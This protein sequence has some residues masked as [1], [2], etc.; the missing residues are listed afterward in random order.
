VRDE[1]GL[2]S[3]SDPLFIERSR[4]LGIS[5][6]DGGEP[7]RAAGLEDEDIEKSREEGRWLVEN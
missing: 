6:T 1:R 7:R 2:R 5:A 3:V 4:L